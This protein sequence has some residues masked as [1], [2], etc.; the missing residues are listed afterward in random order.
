MRGFTATTVPSTGESIGT[1][2]PLASSAMAVSPC[3]REAPTSGSWTRPSGPTS[4][5]AKSLMPTVTVSS[6]SSRT[7]V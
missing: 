5:C 1:D 7:Q 3:A 4:F 2:A 6:P